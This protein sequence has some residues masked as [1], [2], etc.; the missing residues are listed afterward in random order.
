[1]ERLTELFDMVLQ[2]RC[3]ALGEGGLQQDSAAMEIR[4]EGV[5]VDGVGHY[6]N[7]GVEGLDS[8]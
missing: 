1:V 3:S 2:R 7:K 8:V 4:L 6:W 5:D